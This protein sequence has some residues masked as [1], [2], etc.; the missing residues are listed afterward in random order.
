M[1][2]GQ[3]TLVIGQSGG[4]TA[5]INASLA[6]VLRE[7]GRHPQV[8]RVY[9]LVGG[10]EGVLTETFRDLTGESAATL[11]ALCHT[12]G[13]LLR[14]CRT[15]LAPSDDDRLVQV[16]AAHD[17]RYFLYAGG[18]GSMY[19]CLRVRE[20]ARSRGYDVRVVGVPKTVDND[21]LAT[22]HCPGYGSAARFVARTVQDTG[23]DL[24]ALQTFVPVLITEVMGRNAGWLAAAAVLAKE[25]DQDAPHRVYVPERAFDEDSF[26]RDVLRI[27]G[28]R[29]SVSVVVS[30]GIRDAKGE[31]VGSGGS[32]PTDATPWDGP[33]WRWAAVREP[34]WP[35]W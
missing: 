12:P 32:A 2:S 25:T 8:G 26:L 6:G 1:S 5:V 7:A 30:E 21:L 22:D 13:A 19:T 14:S 29:G 20:A 4:P 18:N 11:A 28:E 10:M 23:L 16:L 3:G 24:V 35:I 34:T 31:L 17:V 15:G 33:W 9:G 27:H